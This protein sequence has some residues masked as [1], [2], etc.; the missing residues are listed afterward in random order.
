MPKALIIPPSTIRKRSHSMP[1]SLPPSKP[2]IV[3]HEPSSAESGG[4]NSREI[5]RHE[6]QHIGERD[7]NDGG[8]H[9]FG[10]S[11]LRALDF[12]RDGGSV[13]PTHVIPH[14]HQHAAEQTQT[15]AG[16]GVGA[17]ETQPPS[18][19]PEQRPRRRAAT[20]GRTATAK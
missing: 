14:G 15:A 17:P 9:G 2:P 1:S 18:A 16:C 6:W 20:A 19:A 4:G 8:D 13:V 11:T 12:L 10:I 3:A 7:E 5:D